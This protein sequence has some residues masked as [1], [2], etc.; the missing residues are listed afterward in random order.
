MNL[1]TRILRD[2]RAASAAEY[3]LMLAIIGGAL[4]L[5]AYSLGNTI[6]NSMNE[7]GEQISTCGGSC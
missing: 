7:A 6:A 5:A 3:A 4:A 2:T 1:L